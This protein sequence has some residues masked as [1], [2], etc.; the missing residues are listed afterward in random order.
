MKDATSL[1]RILMLLEQHHLKMI[2]ISN[3]IIESAIVNMRQLEP[4]RIAQV[5]FLLIN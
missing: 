2:D 1:I 4:V 3:I 5:Y